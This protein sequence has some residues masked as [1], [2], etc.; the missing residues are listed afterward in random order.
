[1]QRLI[2]EPR[3]RAAFSAT[4]G[5][6]LAEIEISVFDGPTRLLTLDSTMPPFLNKINDLLPVEQTTSFK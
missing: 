4:T 2:K 5:M 3:L 6:R 1:M